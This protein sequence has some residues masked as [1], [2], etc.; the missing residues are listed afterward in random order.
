VDKQIDSSGRV[1]VYMRIPAELFTV[2]NNM[3]HNKHTTM[4]QVVTDWLEKCVPRKRDKQ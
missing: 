2:L 1:A 4:T 3:A